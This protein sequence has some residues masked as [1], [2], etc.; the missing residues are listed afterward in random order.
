MRW[1]LHQVTRV[2]EKRRG[3]VTRVVPD[4]TPSS[5]SVHDSDQRDYLSPDSPAPRRGSTWPL[6]DPRLCPHLR[7]RRPRRDGE[8][9]PRVLGCHKSTVRTRAPTPWPS[10]S[11]GKET[12]RRQITPLGPVIECDIRVSRPVSPLETSTRVPCLVRIGELRRRDT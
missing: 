3:G 7:R 11:G 9:R 4:V 1:R 12:L 8:T 6:L 5:G 10:Y 2:P